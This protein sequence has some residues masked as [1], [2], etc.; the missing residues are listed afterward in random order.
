[1]PAAETG[2]S[3]VAVP[4]RRTS[5]VE[6][7][8]DLVFVFAVTQISTLLVRDLTWAGFGRAFLVMALVWWAW[9]AFVWTANA[10]DPNSGA[11][12]GVLLL[13]TVLIFITALA[14]PQAYG[15][16][17]V[18]FAAAYT[19]VRLLHLA[20]YADV[21][22][23]G[24]ASFRAIIGFAITV[25]VG[26]AL[27]IA[28][29]VI[30]GVWLIVLWIAAAAI[31]YAGPG[32]LTRRQ[33]VALQAVAVEHFAERYSLFIIICLGESVV[34]IGVGAASRGL[35]ATTIAGTA[36]ML[37][38]TIALWWSY[39]DRLATAAE[40][41]LRTSAA[42]VLA[43]S[44]AYSYLHLILVAGIIVFAAA[45]R[46]AVGR[47]DVPLATA[48]SLALGGGIAIYLCGL[49]AFRARITHRFGL[50]TALGAV[51][52]AAV[53]IAGANTA[54]WVEALALLGILGMVEL[55]ERRSPSS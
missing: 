32:L 41:G 26:M 36:L 47:V 12:R 42:P 7:L 4:A 18:L 39:F 6:L 8:W 27:L 17:A 50:A 30:G 11:V 37:L 25:L 16:G 22:R 33:L 48:E 52:A 20:L 35:D 51:A 5:N 1:L 19:V 55:V 54:A 21:W 3:S 49:V 46:I 23:R 2:A 14:L 34:A 43:A 38:I 29:A 40:D 44:D 28:G 10:D 13:A 31:D 15:A 24:H 53:G 45:A 9:S